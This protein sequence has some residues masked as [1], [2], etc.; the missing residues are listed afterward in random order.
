MPLIGCVLRQIHR[1]GGAQANFAVYPDGSMMGLHD[2][3][4]D[5]KAESCSFTGTFGGKIW[6]EDMIQDAGV[7]AGASRSRLSGIGMLRT[8]YAA[9]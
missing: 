6:I 1:E 3:V 2:A 8:G 4:N 9:V 7:Y 5:G